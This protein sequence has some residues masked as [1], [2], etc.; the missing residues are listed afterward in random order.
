MTYLLKGG[1][2]ATFTKDSDKPSVY[3]ADVL[4]ENSLI[5]QIG[6]NLDADDAHIIDCS[7]KWITPGMV[8]THR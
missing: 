1:T 8:D 7:E 3:A 6:P 2:I 5:K 4:V